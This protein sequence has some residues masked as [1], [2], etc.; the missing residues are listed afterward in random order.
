MYKKENTVPALICFF[1][2][3]LCAIACQKNDQSSINP[4]QIQ[5]INAS[6]DAP[7]LYFLDN[8][9]AIGDSL[10]FP[11]NTSYTALAPVTSKFSITNTAANSLTSFYTTLVPGAFYSLF[12][13]DSFSSIRASMVQDIFF[14]PSPDSMLVRFFHFCPDANYMVAYLENPIDTL[15]LG[16]RSFNDQNTFSTYSNFVEIPAGTYNLQ[17]DIDSSAYIFPLNLSGGKVYTIFAGGFLHGSG[18][19]ALQASLVV[20]N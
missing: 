19:S 4:S 16:T 6:P 17:L 18:S 7:A 20:H 5:C 15:Y 8:Y 9:T 1:I 14:T 2:F 13:I 11:G 10:S 12:A 3:C